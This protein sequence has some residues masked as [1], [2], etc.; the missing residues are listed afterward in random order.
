[1]VRFAANEER[2]CTSS[3]LIRQELE[4]RD[5]C[6]EANSRTN[7]PTLNKVQCQYLQEEKNNFFFFFCKITTVKRK[8][9]NMLDPAPCSQREIF[10]VYT[11]LVVT[12][13]QWNSAR[14][15]FVLF[16]SAVIWF[17]RHGGVTVPTVSTVSTVYKTCKSFKADQP[18]IH[19]FFLFFFYPYYV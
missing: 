15:G 14:P 16:K 17:L 10:T 2:M 3:L 5:V 4:E 18:F 11:K 19:V 8:K 7:C 9:T 6:L 1:M 13:G 12:A